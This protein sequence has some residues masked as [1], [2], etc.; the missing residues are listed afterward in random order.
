M[1]GSSAREI[2]DELIGNGT[3]SSEMPCDATRSRSVE[4]P[5]TD[6][7]SSIFSDGRRLQMWL[8]P[9]AAQARRI[10]S[11]SPCCVPTFILAFGEGAA[12]LAGVLATCADTTASASAAAD[13]PPPASRTNSRRFM[14]PPLPS[15]LIDPMQNMEANFAPTIDPVWTTSQEEPTHTA[16]FLRP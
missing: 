12:G 16:R 3:M 11:E 6:H 4:R 5:S 1:A 14:N 7:A 9:N 8:T 13:T 2:S 15:A 10:W